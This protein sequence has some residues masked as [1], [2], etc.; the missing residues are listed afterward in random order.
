MKKGER[1]VTI[2]KKKITTNVSQR[3]E[4]TKHGSLSASEKKKLLIDL[5]RKEEDVYS[6]EGVEELLESDE[7]EPF[8][9]GYVR[10]EE[11]A[12]TS[13]KKTKKK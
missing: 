5:G 2:K 7:L 9:E 6:D 8:E 1:M 3:S 11:R 10:G 12:Y 13:K 4:S